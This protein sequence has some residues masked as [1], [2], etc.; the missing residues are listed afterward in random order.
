MCALSMCNHTIITV[1]SF[2]WWSA[3]L[4]NGTTVYFKDVAKQNSPL[5]KAFSKDMSDFFFPSWVGLEWNKI[6]FIS[7]FCHSAKIMHDGIT[8]KPVLSGHLLDNEKVA[9]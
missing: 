8:V 2:G 9:L 4:A 5:R 7:S 6:T 1:G 3:W